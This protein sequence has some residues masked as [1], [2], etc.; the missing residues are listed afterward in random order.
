M[1]IDDLQIITT[2]FQKTV[3]ARSGSCQRGDLLGAAKLLLGQ[4][5]YHRQEPLR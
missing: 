1:E 3:C 2:N 5:G 4:E